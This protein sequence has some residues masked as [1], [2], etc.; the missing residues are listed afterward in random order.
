MHTILVPLRSPSHTLA[1]PGEGVFPPIW[2]THLIFPTPS[3]TFSLDLTLVLPEFIKGGLVRGWK[4]GYA[5]VEVPSLEEVALYSMI[6]KVLG[7]PRFLGAK[8]QARTGPL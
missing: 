1:S 4:H 6:S 2:E 5:I 7:R 3:C 8:A